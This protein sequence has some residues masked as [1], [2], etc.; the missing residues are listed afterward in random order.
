MNR[1]IPVR[2]IATRESKSER[3]VSYDICHAIAIMATT[4]DEKSQEQRRCPEAW[5]NV[6]FSRREKAR[7][8]GECYNIEIDSMNQ[9]MNH[10]LFYERLSKNGWIDI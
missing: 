6:V 7:G 1:K 3:K 9:Q 4:E 8:S 2:S 5:Q 10:N